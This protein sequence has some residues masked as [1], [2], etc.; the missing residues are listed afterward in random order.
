MKELL[1]TKGAAAY[2]KLAKQTMAKLRCQGGGPPYYRVGTKICY[3]VAELDV[4]LDARRRRST[5][6]AGPK[7]E[8]PDAS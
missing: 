8:S 2:L 4:W 7:G 1:D 3:A 6:D 5:S